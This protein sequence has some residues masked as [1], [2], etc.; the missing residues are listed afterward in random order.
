MQGCSIGSCELIGRVSSRA[1]PCGSCSDIFPFFERDV[2]LKTS[3]NYFWTSRNCIGQLWPWSRRPCKCIRRPWGSSWQQS[4]IVSRGAMGGKVV[5]TASDWI[6]GPDFKIPKS[7]SE[8][9]VA[10]FCSVRQSPLTVARV[11]PWK[12]FVALRGT[13]GEGDVMVSRAETPWCT[14]WLLHIALGSMLITGVA[15]LLGLGRRVMNIS[16]TRR[17]HPR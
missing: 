14:W 5:V 3:R 1:Y 4:C 13:L 11:R 17:K 8:F 12:V 10:R 7:I 15:I 16:E 6:F 2:T 9:W